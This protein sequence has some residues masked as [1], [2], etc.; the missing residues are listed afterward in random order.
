V[1]S[2]PVRRAAPP[3]APDSVDADPEHDLSLA[4]T[5]PGELAAL[6]EDVPL[7]DR[8]RR[9]ILAMAR[10]A[11]GRDP[12]ALLGMPQGADAKLLKRA[13]FKLSKEIHPD[14][15]YG[16]R[17]GSFTERLP[18]VFEAMSRAYARRPAPSDRAPTRSASPSS[19][20]RRRS[21]P[22]SCSIA[23]ASSRSPAA[24]STR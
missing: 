1:P 2:G 5:T 3:P 19:P 12:W 20:R 4:G 8:T 10:L 22:A 13:Y 17:M 16:Q 6:R 11:D 24:T 14:R 23:R 9:V 18:S 7:D 21:T 15:Y